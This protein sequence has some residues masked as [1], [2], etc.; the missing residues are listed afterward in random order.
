MTMEAGDV[1]TVE[2]PGGGGFGFA[3]ERPVELVVGDVRAGYISM[4]RAQEAYGV[5]IDDDGELDL[6]ATTDKRE[7]MRASVGVEA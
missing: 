1:L 3:F 5:V 4:Q 2:M 6:V 7:Q